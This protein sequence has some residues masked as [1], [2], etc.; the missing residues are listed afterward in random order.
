MITFLKKI[1]QIPKKCKSEQKPLQKE[2]KKSCNLGKVY[3]TNYEYFNCF[4]S[5]KIVLLSKFNK[6]I[7]K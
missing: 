3:L 7:L 4:L 5:S 1:Q 6:I 2:F